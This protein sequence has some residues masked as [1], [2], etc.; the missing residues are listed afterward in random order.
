VKA[1]LSAV[2]E[3]LTDYDDYLDWFLVTNHSKLMVKEGDD[4]EIAEFEFDKPGSAKLTIDSGYRVWLMGK[5][6][7]INSNERTY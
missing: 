4:Q 3:M 2:Y 5:R 1:E 6:A 7:S